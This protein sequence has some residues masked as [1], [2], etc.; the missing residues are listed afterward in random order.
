LGINLNNLKGDLLDVTSFQPNTYY[1]FLSDLNVQLN[2]HTNQLKNIDELAVTIHKTRIHAIALNDQITVNSIKLYQYTYFPLNETF[3]GF[4]EIRFNLYASNLAN[5][6][7][8]S[9]FIDAGHY[10]LT[11]NRHMERP[12]QFF[13]N[14]LTTTKNPNVNPIGVLNDSPIQD[15]IIDNI[16]ANNYESIRF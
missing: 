3:I 1:N 4:A 6:F 15:C 12:P 11:I 5:T 13:Y 10:H 14:I 7:V 8:S 16:W 9:L 2:A